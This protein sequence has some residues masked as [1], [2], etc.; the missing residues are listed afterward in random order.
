MAILSFIL[1]ISTLVSLSSFGCSELTNPVQNGAG[2]RIR[3]IGQ[4]RFAR[5][6]HAATLLSDGRVLITGGFQTGG[7]SLSDAEVYVPSTG[8]LRSIEKMNA[9]R[10]GHTSTKLPDGKIL[11][12]GGYDGDYLETTELFDPRSGE[13]SDGP[14]MTTP[15][16]EHTA[17]ILADGRV[18][19]AGGV[20][21]GW[22][23][24]AAAE[25][26]DPAS[27]KFTAVG[28]MS[29]PRESH[30]A[31]LLKDGRVLITGGH[32]DRRS[33]MTIFAS[34]EVFIPSKN[35]FEGV[36]DMKVKR[37]KHAAILLPDGNVLIAGGS[38][39]R[40]SRGAYAS[41]EIFEPLARD[42]KLAG[43]MRRARYKLNGAVAMLPNGKV[44]IAGGSDGAE[45]F[46]PATRTTIDVGG[47][48]G[49]HRLF[50][51]ATLL[52]DGR[53]LIAGGYDQRTQVSS[54][55]WIFE[56]STEEGVN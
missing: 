40:D 50:T 2:G 15:R 48:F 11:I 54:G 16:S 41:L 10:A 49:S 44:L 4:L 18:M 30:T 29:V 20:G 3:Q 19:I 51:T 28:N 12:A 53:V 32:K 56:G 21:T 34:S 46:D 17:T 39:E 36:G 9:A 7:R 31:T 24:L 35:I 37:H 1:T 8:E 33:A 6:A 38:D 22:T 42:F 52:S 47:S 26:Y 23:F 55:A 43:E 5:A 27:G 14:K 13:F 45:L 25:I